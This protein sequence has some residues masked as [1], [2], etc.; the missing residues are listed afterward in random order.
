MC[1]YCKETFTGNTNDDLV[2]VEIK[3]NGLS[4]F[5][6]HTYVDDSNGKTYIKSHLDDEHGRYIAAETMEIFYCPV[7]GR[8]LR[9]ES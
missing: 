8:K 5:G 3:V 7:C 9:N 1:K 4:L 2:G 6:I